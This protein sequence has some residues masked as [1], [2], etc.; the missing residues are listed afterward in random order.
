MTNSITTAAASAGA[1]ALTPYQKQCD[2]LKKACQ[3][4]EGVFLG[5][6]LKQMRHSVQ[7]GQ[8]LYGSS[9]EDKTYQGMMDAQLARLMSKSGSL[10]MAQ[11]LYREM[12]PLLPGAPVPA[13]PGAASPPSAVPAPAAASVL[14]APVSPASVVSAAA[15]AADLEK[16]K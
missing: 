4:F 16:G 13:S 10:G 14:P 15:L 11:Q 2:R 1:A 7:Q 3:E 12:K 8:S 9:Y 5:M 6:V